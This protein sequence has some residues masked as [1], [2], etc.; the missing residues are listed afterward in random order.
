MG[1][2]LSER[3]RP[4]P[5]RHPQQRLQDAL[6][7]RSQVH[8]REHVLPRRQALLPGMPSPPEHPSASPPRTA[9][10]GRNPLMDISDTLAPHSDQLDAVDLLGGDQTFTN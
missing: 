3:A 1:H 10:E 5:P 6:P 4:R 8:A 2:A 7:P 9:A